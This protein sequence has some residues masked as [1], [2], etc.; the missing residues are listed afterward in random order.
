MTRETPPQ[1][2]SQN[3]EYRDVHL[4]LFSSHPYW[5]ER[6]SD[7]IRRGLVGAALFL[8]LLVTYL[9]LRG[10]GIDRMIPT[11]GTWLV[12]DSG[13]T[14]AGITAFSIGMMAAATFQ[15][16]MALR[17]QV[18]DLARQRDLP[19]SFSPATAL[20]LGLAGFVLPLVLTFAPGLPFEVRFFGALIALTPAV[21][22]SLLLPAP[23]SRAS[24]FPWFSGG[25]LIPLLTL[26]C[27]S[28]SVAIWM[29]D[30]LPQWIIEYFPVLR[31][32]DGIRQSC[33]SL[34]SMTAVVFAFNLLSWLQGM[35]FAKEL[36][37]T[38][39]TENKSSFWKRLLRALG[40]RGK[41]EDEV[42]IAAREADERRKQLVE[43]TLKLAQECGF[44]PETAHEVCPE[45]DELSQAC[46]DSSFDL[47]FGGRRPTLDQFK[48]LRDFNDLSSLCIDD[49]EGRVDGTGF[50]MII[51]GPAGSGRSSTL[52]AMA[53]LTLLGK[54]AGTVMLVADV[55]RINFAIQRL[56]NRIESIHLAPYA[57]VGSV[58]D[59]WSRAV[60]GEAPPDICV[61]TPELWEQSLPGQMVREGTDY[62]TARILMIHYSTMLVD[63]WLEHPVEIR[64]HLPFVI[65]KHRL[66]LES[67]MLPRACVVA[68]PS[69]TDTGRNLAVSRLMGDA[70]VIDE[71][72]QV[73]RLRYRPMAASTLVD[74]VCDSVDEAIDKLAS[75]LSHSGETSILLRKGID[76]EEAERQTLDYQTRYQ[77]SKI[78]VC[79]C[80]DQVET[81]DGEMRAILMKASCG[82]EAVFALRAH[83]HENSLVMIRVRDRREIGSI[84]RITPLIVDRSGR[85]MAESHLRNILRFMD[86]QSPVSRRC[87]GQ[88]GLDIPTQGS[89]LPVKTTGTLVLDLPELLPES[90]RRARPYL[91]KLGSYISLK[92][93]FKY[94][95]RMDCHWIPDPG[96][97]SVAREVLG[98]AA[99]TTLHLPVP[100]EAG[101]HEKGSS[102]L[103][104]GNEGSELGRT[105]LQYTESLLLKRRRVFCPDRIREGTSRGLEI[106][107]SKFRDNGRDAIHPKI[108]LEWI[109]KDEAVENGPSE[110]SITPNSD[111]L[112]SV[113]T[114]YGGP[115]HGF[116]WADLAS[117]AGVQ[118]NSRLI[119]RV[120]D[121]DRPSPCFAHPYEWRAR[122]RP[123][124]L[125]PTDA[126]IEQQ[127]EYL[128]TLKS[129]FAQS[130]EWGTG[131]TSFLPGLTYALTRGLEVD[132]PSSGFFGKV[133]AF[134]LEG[135]MRK[136][137][138]A[139]VWFV[140]PIGT[141][142]TL[143]NAVHELLKEEGYLKE[144]ATRMDK[145][146][147]QGWEKSPLNELA[148]FWLPRK[149]RKAVILGER[150]IV[151]NLL[152]ESKLDLPD[153]ASIKH[154]VICPHCSVEAD[155][156]V[157]V[158]GGLQSLIHCNQVISMAVPTAA[159]G[160]TSPL[161]LVKSWWPSNLPIPTGSIEEKCL[162]TWALVANQVVY[163]LDHHQR[164]G[165]DECWL[166]AE[167]TWKRGEGDCED[168]S[169]LLA[170]MLQHLGINAWVVWGQVDDGGHAWV[171]VEI[172][173][174]VK[175]IEA[176]AKQPLPEQLPSTEEAGAVYGVGS[177]KPDLHIPARTNGVVYETLTDG[178]WQ[179]VSLPEAMLR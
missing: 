154:K 71:R 110:N 162:A 32:L 44:S 141:G 50:E 63:D 36:E 152:G 40:L 45:L 62:E 170:N 101:I 89:R 179:E 171:E 127:E 35:K 18:G 155:W 115:H 138:E 25:V 68:F 143:S 94:L 96:P 146:L 9:W 130:R 80:G 52:D 86:P 41:P 99:P 66:F 14:V 19:V 128:K 93:R 106:E 166:P 21:T 53:M 174:A 12:S 126:V 114:G 140:E 150:R 121:M 95:E 73:I 81:L 125:G 113:S 112:V 145:I 129:F 108:E 46:D 72:R 4:G 1:A 137:A 88:L 67:E 79:Y 87:W 119:E 116:I 77:S 105:Q 74:V 37:T 165:V 6:G 11:F 169:I 42:E 57:T 10:Q 33:M 124:L 8:Y 60:I 163:S 100:D 148:R 70:G 28:D 156:E 56:R 76:F 13:R 132:L 173:D 22:L 133:L 3:R 59:A 172:Q 144:L 139:V 123:L 15:F 177:Y 29:Q 82:L 157:S 61:T 23:P 91:A 178:V 83:R 118:V 175:I 158:H 54:G 58:Q 159:G 167:E 160:I 92:D 161:N 120:D 31:T 151:S 107:A 149:H 98:Q 111:R 164:E 136:F 20:V 49:P 64:A 30:R 39:E 104:L 142:R 153:H 43:W 102:V 65:D 122:V 5:L 7:W 2:E 78:K 84:N 168:H 135:S 24:M 109:Q 69:L 47:L 26:C 34:C 131:H 27:L 55:G 90:E 75:A 48:A 17:K 38:A 51:E 97:M 176:T 16:R 103:W 147:R 134:R 117:S 85:G